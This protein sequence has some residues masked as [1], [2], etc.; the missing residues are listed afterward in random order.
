MKARFSMVVLV[1]VAAVL[2]MSMSVSAT[3]TLL[4]VDESWSVNVGYFLTKIDK[5]FFQGKFAEEHPNAAKVKFFLDKLGLLTLQDNYGEFK[6]DE[7]GLYYKETT[8]LDPEVKD[9]LLATKYL[10]D[11]GILVKDLNNY[12]DGG[13]VTKNCLRITMP[14]RTELN[15]L[16]Q[17]L[18]KLTKQTI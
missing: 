14:P 15:R 9:S 18:L 6:L 2:L 4:K 10:A 7:S 12:P 11:S 3:E 17:A 13:E 16:K 1:S 8:T 5:I